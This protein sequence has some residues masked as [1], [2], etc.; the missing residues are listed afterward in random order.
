M[1][2]GLLKLLSL[3][4]VFPSFDFNNPIILHILGLLTKYRWIFINTPETI[5]KGHLHRKCNSLSIS[6][7]SQNKLFGSS[8]VLEV[9]SYFTVR[10]HSVMNRMYLY[11]I[12]KYYKFYFTFGINVCM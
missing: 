2:E 8:A 6:F 11:F 5:K 1:K 12:P 7:K 9:H 3:R 10:I 4:R